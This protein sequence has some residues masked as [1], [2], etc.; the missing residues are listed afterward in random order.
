MS[1]RAFGAL[2]ALALLA[3]L[4][5]VGL[6]L[7]AVLADV[8]PGRLAGKLGEGVTL[9]ALRVSFESSAIAL[10]ALVAIGTPV[11]W[12]LATRRFRGR[13]AL[14]TLFE[15]PLVLPPAVAGIGLLAAFGPD[16]AAGRLLGHAGIEL[17]L[18]MAAVVCAQ[19]FVA[20]PFYIRQASAAFAAIDPRLLAAAR[21]LGAGEAGAFAR[22]AIPVARPGLAAGAALAWG[23][24]IGEFGA[25]LLFAGSLRGTT[26]TASTAIYALF[27]SDYPGALALAAVLLLLSAAV[28][29]GARATTARARP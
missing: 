21:T 24:A 29:V 7:G 2:L 26:Q 15:L 23:R 10:A 12:L 16:S 19:A 17:P 13:D 5:F 6:P 14:A 8:G 25:T 18:T 11:A 27:G 1:R 9:D 28:M 4:A 22:V 20:A 3:A